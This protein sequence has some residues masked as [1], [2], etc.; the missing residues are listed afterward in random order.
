MWRWRINNK[1]LERCESVTCLYF[2]NSVRQRSI[3]RHTD[4]HSTESKNIRRRKHFLENYLTCFERIFLMTLTFL[5]GVCYRFFNIENH[6][7]RKFS[8]DTEYPLYE[9]NRQQTD[10]LR[11]FVV[12][13]HYLHKFVSILLLSNLFLPI[14]GIFLVLQ[15]LFLFMQ[16]VVFSPI[17]LL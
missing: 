14:Y 3:H 13:I 8:E 7:I 5:C 10:E 6:F 9:L 12:F 11:F 17:T 1:E 15:L 16:S 4:I 2:V